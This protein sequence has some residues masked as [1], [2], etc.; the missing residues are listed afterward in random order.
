MARCVLYPVRVAAAPG[1]AWRWRTADAGSAAISNNHFLL[2]YDCVKD[3]Q[4]HGHSVDLDATLKV[5]TQ[6]D[7]RAP[8]AQP[9]RE[10]AEQPNE[11]LA[12]NVT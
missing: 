1:Y 9:D 3:A 10:T 12:E 4:R 11:R 5:A 6:Y 7:A 8:E 2:F